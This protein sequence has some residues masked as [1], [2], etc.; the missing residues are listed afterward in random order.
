MET[1]MPL[2]LQALPLSLK[3][4]WRYLFLLP[5]LTAL[6]IAVTLAAGFIPIIGLIVP[7]IMSVLCTL[8]GLRCAL[9]ARGHDS[10]LDLGKL[11]RASF[12]YFVL[13]IVVGLAVTLL[14]AGLGMVA[15]LADGGGAASQPGDSA[16]GG[17]V[18][19]IGGLAAALAYLL[20][21]CAMAV[22]MTAA[23]ATATIRGT[24]SDIFWGFGS[25]VVSLAVVSVLGF[26][27]NA[28]LF[29]AFHQAIGLFVILQSDVSDLV[30]SFLALPH[31]EIVIPVTI[32]SISFA[33]WTTCWFFATAVLAWE[34]EKGQTA[35]MRQAALAPRVSA[36]DLRALREARMRGKSDI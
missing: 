33:I 4:F 3:T 16:I 5:F 17:S 9:K 8:A 23:A 36:E 26:L 21:M 1:F 29:L 18:V 34:R 20:L 10:D 2:F 15:A 7:G 28:A 22:P 11:V 6:T 27:G 25:G 12:W 13:G 32:G 19:A 35:Q 30:Q 24:Q 31:L 14:I